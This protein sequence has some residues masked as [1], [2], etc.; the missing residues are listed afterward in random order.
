MEV[1]VGRAPGSQ[2][3]QKF[4]FL[5][6]YS[7]YLFIFFS[8]MLFKTE[9]GKSW[10]KVVLDFSTS[11]SLMFSFCSSPLRRR[12]C[13]MSPTRG[14]SGSPQEP[15][16]GTFPPATCVSCVSGTQTLQNHRSENQ[17]TKSLGIRPSVHRFLYLLPPIQSSAGARSCC[18]N[19]QQ[20]S[21]IFTSW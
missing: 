13:H 2:E 20:S 12:R 10:C 16:R 5:Q 19:L 17:K 1:L 15:S 21:T 4:H 3:V 11:G 14:G 9:N 8:T 6:M 7:S 18:H